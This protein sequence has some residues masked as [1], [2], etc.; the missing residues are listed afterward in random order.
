MDSRNLLRRRING[1]LVLR[2]EH[3]LLSTGNACYHHDVS[4]TF[5]PCAKF[6]C[7]YCLNFL[8]NRAVCC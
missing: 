6:L 2:L 5:K 7:F 4:I 1:C 8:F 3:K